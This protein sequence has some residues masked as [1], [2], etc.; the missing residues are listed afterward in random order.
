[1]F[2][3]WGSEYSAELENRE[4]VLLDRCVGFLTG[5]LVEMLI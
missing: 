4:S 2:F 1:V 5:S 3:V